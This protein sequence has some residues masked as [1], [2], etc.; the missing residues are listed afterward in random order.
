MPPKEARAA[1]LRFFPAAAAVMVAFPAAPFTADPRH[2]DISMATAF[3]QQPAEADMV[4]MPE[5]GLASGFAFTAGHVKNTYTLIFDDQSQPSAT[6]D[7]HMVQ[8]VS[9]SD[10]SYPAVDDSEAPSAFPRA[11]TPW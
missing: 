6:T 11:S 5:F 9:N 7:H 8:L 10:L 1:R 2:A 3:A 4:H